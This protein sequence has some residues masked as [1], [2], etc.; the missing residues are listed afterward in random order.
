MKKCVG[1]HDYIIIHFLREESHFADYIYRYRWIVF[2][3]PN[4]YGLSASTV[5][6][7]RGYESD[8]ERDGGSQ[9]ECY[10][11][12]GEYVLDA[13]DFI[14]VNPYQN[15]V[16]S[17]FHCHT[18]HMHNVHLLMAFTCNSMSSAGIVGH[19]YL[20]LGACRCE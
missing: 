20:L 4:Y 16:V 18:L 1:T 10:V 7:L 9:L 8:C 11:S 12:S 19:D 15:V 17:Y 14:N 6:L 3:N 13:F 5:T 2:I